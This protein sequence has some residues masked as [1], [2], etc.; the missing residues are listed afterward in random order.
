MGSLTA[1][2]PDVLEGQAGINRAMFLRQ[3]G[4]EWLPSIPDLHARL[5]SDPPARVADIGCGGLVQHRDRPGLSQAARR[6]FRPRRAVG[7][8]RPSRTPIEAATE[9]VHPPAG[10]RR[11]V[12]GGSYDLVTAFEC[13]HDMADPV[14]ALRTMR[15][16][17]G[18]RAALI[19]M[20]ERVGD[21]FTATRQRRGVDDVRLERAALPA[22]RDSGGAVGGDGHRHAAGDAAPLRAEAGFARSSLPIDNFFFRFYQLN[23]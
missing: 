3:L 14:G 11:P 19:V 6:R 2:G 17:A 22:R 15:R 10:R 20:D 18:E 5:I 23:A 16:L 9:R 1:Y 21:R 8:A 13:I 12:A 4:A 7:R